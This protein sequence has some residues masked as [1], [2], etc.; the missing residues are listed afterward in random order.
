MNLGVIATGGI[1][2]SIYG[3]IISEKINRASA[4]VFG[5]ALMV[6]LGLVAEEKVVGYIDFGT[7]GLLLGMMIIVN[8]M[9]RTGIF[10][11]VALRAAKAVHANPWFM[12]LMFG[13]ITAVASAF[14]DNV[15]TILLL[16]PVTFVIT[17]IL[18]VDPY[19][20]IFIEVL[21]ANIGG[22]AT[23]IGDPPNIM[24]GSENGLSFLD[25]LIN[26]GPVTV[27]IA[28]VTMFIIWA[29]Y[30]RKL[31][32]SDEAKKK[33][34]SLD[35]TVAIKDHKL[36]VKSLLA[37]GFTVAGFI[38]HS[39]FDLESATIALS[40]AAILMFISGMDMEEIFMDIE[41]TTIFFFVALFVLVGGL[42]EAG[43]IRWIADWMIQVTAGNEVM[44]MLIILWGSAI[45]SSFLDNIPF[46]ATM[47]PL[48]QSMTEASQ[49]NAMPLWWAL[50]LGAC[51]GGNGTMIG[52]SANVI[53]CGMLEKRGHKVKFLEYMKHAYPLM[54][55]SMIIST[56][57]LLVTY[58]L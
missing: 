27:I 26:L 51:L 3:I 29:V 49:M 45:L 18:E 47:I 41:W 19:P 58:E 9:K 38:T 25:F 57:Y 34:M 15:T 14:L 31:H 23:L 28:A 35:H 55:V 54:L 43:I 50:A 32:V 12:M 46:V 17:Q 8:I 7:I 30:G 13:I 1:F 4:A 24:I 37:L 39:F 10:E 16:G 56:I 5:A 11:Y 20:Y 22:T 36:L 52:A 53:A 42:E 40:G 2:L 33:I 48:I 21:M 6:L 44:L